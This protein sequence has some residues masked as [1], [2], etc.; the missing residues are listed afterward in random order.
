M[1][2]ADSRLLVPVCFEVQSSKKKTCG[3]AYDK[4]V[5]AVSG[6]F[7]C[8]MPPTKFA[9]LT[10]SVVQCWAGAKERVRYD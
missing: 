9:F 7:A 1:L 4:V 6:C 2:P 5:L 8:A 3:A 10:A